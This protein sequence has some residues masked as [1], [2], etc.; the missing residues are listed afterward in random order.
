MR[1]LNPR[2]ASFS[3]HFLGGR[4]NGLVYVL[5]YAH[6][7][8]GIRA[9]LHITATFECNLPLHSC[10]LTHV[11]RWLGIVNKLSADG[12]LSTGR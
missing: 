12:P 1:G 4:K 6:K 10:I 11:G 8:L 9:Y 7:N 3:G 2:V 5:P